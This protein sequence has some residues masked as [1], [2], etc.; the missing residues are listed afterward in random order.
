MKVQW[1]VPDVIAE[2][3]ALLLYFMRHVELAW[4]IKFD[5]VGRLYYTIVVLRCNYVWSRF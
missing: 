1:P 3:K 4:Q 5:L 2:F